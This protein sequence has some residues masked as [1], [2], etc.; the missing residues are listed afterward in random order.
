M[1]DFSQAQDTLINAYNEVICLVD[2]NTFNIKQLKFCVL[3]VKNVNSVVQAYNVCSF[4]NM[5]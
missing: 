3:F 2:A 1:L 4:M 5:T